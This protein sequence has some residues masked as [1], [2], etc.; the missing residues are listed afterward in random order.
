MI[1]LDVDG[2]KGLNGSLASEAAEEIMNSER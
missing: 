2:L 1:E